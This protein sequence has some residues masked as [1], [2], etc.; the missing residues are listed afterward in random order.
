MTILLIGTY[1]KVQL[2]RPQAPLRERKKA[3]IAGLNGKGTNRVAQS[4]NSTG[5][6]LNNPT[7]QWALRSKVGATPGDEVEGT[8]S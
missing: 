3:G 4:H 1:R 2:P 8:T 7:T 5:T 6:A